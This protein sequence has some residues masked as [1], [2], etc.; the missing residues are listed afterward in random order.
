[1]RSRLALL[2]SWL[3]PLVW[4]IVIFKGSGDAQSYQHTST[5]FEPLMHWLFPSMSEAHIQ[6]AH[7]LF[8][9][10][11]HLTEYAFLAVLCWRAIRQ[12]ASQPPCPWHWR[13][14]AL[15]LG[16][17]LVYAASDELHQGLVPGR[18]GQVA[19]VAVDVAGGALGLAVLWTCHRIW[20]RWR[21]PRAITATGQEDGVC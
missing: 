8:R 19:D 20:S 12:P 7:Y 3:P 16:L 18:T 14:A 13:E 2:R 9:K 10:C 1:M 4:M 15:A 21:R 11:A 5:I 6:T 17:V